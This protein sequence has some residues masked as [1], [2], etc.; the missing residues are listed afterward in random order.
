MISALAQEIVTLVI[1]LASGYAGAFLLGAKSI[2]HAVSLGLGLSVMWRVVS[3]SLLYLIGMGNYSQ[4]VWLIGSLIVMVL[5]IALELKSKSLWLGIGISTLVG[6]VSGIATRGLGLRGIEHSDSLWIMTLSDLM[7]RNGDLE[8]LG[9]RTAIKR[10]FS[11]PLT[12]ALGPEG[13]SLTGLTVMIYLALVIAIIW[14]AMRLAPR[15]S[16][17]QWAIFLLPLGLVLATAPIV[18]RAIWYVNGHTLTALGVVLGV[19]AVVLSIREGSL[20]RIHL[21]T[22][23]IGLALIS[24]TRPEGIAF[25]ALI[26]APLLQQRWISRLDIRLIV[27]SALGSFGLWIYVYDGYVATPLRLYDER[28][29]IAMVLASVLVGFKIFDW[30]RFRLVALAFISMGLITTFMVVSNF[31]SL[32]DDFLAQFQNMFLG[33]GFWGGFF[34]FC[35]VALFVIGLRQMSPSYRLLLTIS[36]LLFLGSVMAK[37]LDGGFFGDPTLGR[38]GWTD[39]LNRM[40][41]QSFGIFALTVI[42]GYAE[43]VTKKVKSLV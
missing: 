6:L 5:A 24:T 22:L 12:L 15:L 28:F 16:V 42:I 10:G 3:H 37:L 13:S 14:A 8:I 7:Q 19:T 41:L 40:W 18:F 21:V 11:Y 27:F 23:M 17:R 43:S 39:S 2:A 9:G 30:F 32:Q 1:L 34:I 35:L 4:M 20:S 33:Q 31:S 38:L 29:P 26:A 36:A 25:A